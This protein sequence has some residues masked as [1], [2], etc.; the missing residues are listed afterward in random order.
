MDA[1]LHW[2]FKEFIG[3]LTINFRYVSNGNYGGLFRGNKTIDFWGTNAGQLPLE[4]IFHEF[5][6][7]PEQPAVLPA[8]KPC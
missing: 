8:M 1:A 2:E 3:S 4:N 6:H 5:G 7:L